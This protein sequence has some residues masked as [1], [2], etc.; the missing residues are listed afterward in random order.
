MISFGRP[1]TSPWPTDF[2]FGRSTIPVIAPYWN[3][4]DFRNSVEDSGLYYH[5]YTSSET[6]RDKAFLLELSNRLKDYTGSEDFDPN[7]MIVVTW[8]KASP[9][10]GRA[11]SDE[12]N[13][14]NYS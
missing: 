1:F 9:Y 10:Y 8:Y 2:L 13:G 6:K 5:T 4:L 14:S 7:W 12:V 3:D 11:N